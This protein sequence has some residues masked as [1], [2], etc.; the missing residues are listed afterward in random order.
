MAGEGWVRCGGCAEGWPGWFR[1][2][3]EPAC[4]SLHFEGESRE[5]L[6]RLFTEPRMARA[7]PALPPGS[8]GPAAGQGSQASQPCFTEVEVGRSRGSCWHHLA[9]R[10]KNCLSSPAWSVNP[11]KLPPA[12]GLE[13]R[14]RGKKC[15]SSPARSV[16]PAKLS[17]ALGLEDRSRWGERPQAQETGVTQPVGAGAPH[18]T[19]LSQGCLPQ[20]RQRKAGLSPAMQPSRPPPAGVGLCLP[21][22]LTLPSSPRPVSQRGLLHRRHQHG[23]LRVPAR[24]PGHFL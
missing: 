1:R 24:L 9:G 17:P 10:G 3:S 13:D 7:R 5:L 6:P 12:L 16:K 2:A 20:P 21:L 14:S 18:Q 19:P 15:H 8:S 23:L 22:T 4:S 11:A